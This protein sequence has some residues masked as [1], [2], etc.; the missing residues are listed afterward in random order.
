MTPNVN[1]ESDLIYGLPFAPGFNPSNDFP[2][3]QGYAG[4]VEQIRGMIRRQKK[5][6]GVSIAIA[7][8]VNITPVIL[9][10]MGRIFLGFKLSG[11]A[12]G[13]LFGLL[14]NNERVI[15]NGTTTNFINLANSEGEY[16]SFPRPLSGS[17]SIIFEYVATGGFDLAVNFYYI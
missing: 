5:V 7:A 10:G 12:I 2:G 9:S 8:G 11:G 6:Q 14:I 1:I 15:T 3:S 16:Y 17:D 4:T 13:D